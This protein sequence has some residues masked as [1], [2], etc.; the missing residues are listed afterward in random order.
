MHGKAHQGARIDCGIGTTTLVEFRV[1]AE[2]ET[3]DGLT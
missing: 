3:L 1:A 2:P